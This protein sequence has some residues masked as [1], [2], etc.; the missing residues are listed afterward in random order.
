MYTVTSSDDTTIAFD[1]AGSGPMILFV[2]GVFNDRSTC[3]ELAELLAHRFTVVTYDRR[4]HGDSTDTAPYSIDREI[5]DIDRVIAAVG[6]PAYLF[7][8]SSGGLLALMAAARGSAIT[9]VAVYEAPYLLSDDAQP[10]DL[11]EQ[12]AELIAQGR[13]GDAVELYQRRGIGLDAETV[14]QIRQAPFWPALEAVAPTVV[15]DA[16][17]TRRDA[18]PAAALASITTPTL[19]L[20]GAQTWDKLRRGAHAIIEAMPTARLCTLSAGRD[21]ELPPEALA[22][23][24]GSFFGAGQ[25][26]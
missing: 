3:A 1:R 16:T 11:P 6:G 15:Y 13:R 20:T 21:H 25:P 5:D 7:G 12:I 14:A 18:L 4:G 9:K 24:L 22:P 10:A 19:V 2:T 8:Y 26:A 17:I 23:E